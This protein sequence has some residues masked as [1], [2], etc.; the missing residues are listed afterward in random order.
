MVTFI[1]CGRATRAA[2]TSRAT[3]T[4]SSPCSSA[5]PAPLLRLGVRLLRWLDALEP[6]A[7]RLHSPRPALREPVHDQLGSVKLESPF[8]HLYEYG[9][10]PIFAA[11]GLK[12]DVMTPGGVKTVC[13]VK[14]TLDE[15]IEDGLYCAQ[16][17][18][19]LRRY[20]EDPGAA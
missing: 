18:E 7:R 10:I 6:A 5:C 4:K 3:S 2:A 12:R 14:Y 9:N 11:I 17:L 1:Y 8:H 16:S 20:V 15:R 13:S 19:I